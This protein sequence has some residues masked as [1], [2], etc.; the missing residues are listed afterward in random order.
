MIAVVVFQPAQELSG[1]QFG[2][3]SLLYGRKWPANTVFATEMHSSQGSHHLFVVATL[4]NNS[5]RAY[6][7]MLHQI[8]E[9]YL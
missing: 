6:C 4:V 1:Y 5:M 9:N 2:N 3:L 8:P 7:A